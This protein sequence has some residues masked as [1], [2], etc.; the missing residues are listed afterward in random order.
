MSYNDPFTY[1]DAK[2]IPD[3]SVDSSV[4]FTICKNYEPDEF[5]G[6]GKHMLFFMPGR[7]TI[8]EHHQEK[9]P[10]SPELSYKNHVNHDVILKNAH[11]S[12]VSGVPGTWY[13]P[14]FEYRIISAGFKIHNVGSS[15]NISGQYELFDIPIDPSPNN[16]IIKQ[17]TEDVT[18]YLGTVHNESFTEKVYKDVTQHQYYSTGNIVD[19]EN[20]TIK[21]N[22][23]VTDHE[24]ITN[25]LQY[26]ITT[27]PAPNS[28]QL[29]PTDANNVWLLQDT[30]D[31]QYLMKGLILN[32]AANQKI[33]IEMR[34]NYE[35]ITNDNDIMRHK[36]YSGVYGPLP[37]PG[38]DRNARPG[39]GDN[40]GDNQG[41]GSG[42]PFVSP[43]KSTPYKRKNDNIG[44]HIVKKNHNPRQHQNT[45]NDNMDEDVDISISHMQEKLDMQNVQE[46]DIDLNS[47]SWDD[48]ISDEDIE[49]V[50]AEETAEAIYKTFTGW[51]PAPIGD[52]FADKGAIRAGNT[53]YESKAGQLYIKNHPGDKKSEF[54]IDAHEEAE[55]QFDSKDPGHRN[56]QIF[57]TAKKIPG[58]LFNL[59][60]DKD[61]HHN[62]DEYERE[63]EEDR[64]E[65]AKEKKEREKEEMNAESDESDEEFDYDEP[66][67]NL[68]TVSPNKAS[69]KPTKKAHKKQSQTKN[70]L[71]KKN[72]IMTNQC[73]IYLQYHQIKH[74]E[75]PLKRLIRNNHK[76]KIN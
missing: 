69:R 56:H 41:D 63:K 36:E 21:L 1:K 17:K 71:T 4:C 14:F 3:K 65:T 32:I 47:G 64:K 2:G 45:N 75:N 46:D 37:R 8:L 68:P 39:G 23:K 61:M 74:Q 13:T 50:E 5:N 11:Q 52:E 26:D 31:N 72:S 43:D 24:F 49:E 27:L 59:F 19:L 53:M 42:G 12:A 15:K 44:G 34:T 73:T 6:G 51:N 10:G 76:R 25:K 40:D 58:D 54:M 29:A 18:T 48:N 66:M 57:E 60:L 7:N 67:Y 9:T 55:L 33:V 28:E 22:S 38:D 16:F 30:I 62:R 20:N 70:K 35:I